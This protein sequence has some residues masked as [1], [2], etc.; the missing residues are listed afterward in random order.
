MR[1][2]NRI[3]NRKKLVGI[4]LLFILVFTFCTL[5]FGGVGASAGEKPRTAYYTTVTVQPGDSLWS[6]AE[7]YAPAYSDLQD[8]VDQL[9]NINRIRRGDLIRAGEQLVIVYYQ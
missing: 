3:H 9:R 8:Y 1:R 2:R 5:C 4:C 7:R 6:L